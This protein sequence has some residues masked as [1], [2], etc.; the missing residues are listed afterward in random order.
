MGFTEFEQAAEENDKKVWRSIAP[1]GTLSIEEDA[2]QIVPAIRFTPHASDLNSVTEAIG[3]FLSAAVGTDISAQ[4]K[5]SLL[6]M[7]T[8]LSEK[9]AS[10]VASTTVQNLDFS[11]TW[12]PADQTFCF[13]LGKSGVRTSRWYSLPQYVQRRFHSI[14]R[15]P[16]DLHLQSYPSQKR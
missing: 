8:I 12:E 6:Q 16:H 7:L 1:I 14:L 4:D 10:D 13:L 9:Q 2:L 3:Q 5:D 11:I 15:F